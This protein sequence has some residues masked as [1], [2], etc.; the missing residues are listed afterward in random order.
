MALTRR[1]VEVRRQEGTSTSQLGALGS[2]RVAAPRAPPPP[3]CPRLRVATPPPGAAASALRV[4]EQVQAGAGWVRQP[5]ETKPAFSVG[6]L[7]KAV[8]AHCW[9]RSL[10]RSSAYLLADLAMLAALVYASTHIDA[11]PVPAAVRWLA[12]WPAYWFFAGAVATGLW[13]SGAASAL[14]G[15]CWERGR[16]HLG[17]RNAPGGWQLGGAPHQPPTSKPAAGRRHVGATL[18]P[19]L[20]RAGE[21]HSLA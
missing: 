17:F 3:A 14:V 5:V 16:L 13:V 11:A 12:L 6:T 15:W 1:A 2:S 21:D 18:N 7:R 19:T 9:Q 10:W 4:Q 20:E 8:P